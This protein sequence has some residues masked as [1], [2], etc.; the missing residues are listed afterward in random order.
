MSWFD[1]LR[2]MMATEANPPLATL[3]LIGDAAAP[4]LIA[5]A[6]Y[7]G[8]KAARDFERDKAEVD[9]SIFRREIIAL[10]EH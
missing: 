8:H 1:R 3:E 5:D 6:V 4:G 10:S 9:A 7:S 2:Q